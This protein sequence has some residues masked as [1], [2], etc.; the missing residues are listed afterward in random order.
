MKPGSDCRLYRPAGEIS[1]VD[2]VA[3]ASLRDGTNTFLDY[4][5]PS[6]AVGGITLPRDIA[7]WF[8]SSHFLQVVN[9][10]NLYFDGDLLTVIKAHQQYCAGNHVCL[11]IGA[12]VLQG[13]R[14]GTTFPDHWVVL[15]SQ[16]RIGGVLATTLA[17]LGSKVKDDDALLGSP[18]EFDVYTW[19]KPSRGI[20]DGW[21]G[22]KVRDF[23]EY[24]YGFVAAK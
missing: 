1:P 20:T 9:R 24:F 3:L 21:P 7:G 13:K 22:L 19:G 16:I 18:I 4:D 23:L 10:T 5:V 11:L 6:V 2:W 8:G 15:S 17:G 12:N 14:T